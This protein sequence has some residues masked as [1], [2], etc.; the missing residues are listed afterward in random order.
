VPIQLPLLTLVKLKR[1]YPGKIAARS[2]TF[3]RL[4]RDAKAALFTKP[5]LTIA[6]VRKEFL[7]PAFFD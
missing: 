1:C 7:L 6:S 4:D 3:P 2:I 5:S